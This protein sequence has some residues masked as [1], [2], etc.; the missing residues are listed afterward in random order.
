MRRRQNDGWQR[1]RPSSSKCNSEGGG[2][3]ENLKRPYESFKP[4][5][6]KSEPKWL[7]Q[8][9]LTAG[10]TEENK[11]KVRKYD[12][13]MADF[14]PEEKKKRVFNVRS[15][16]RGYKREDTKMLEDFLA[17]LYF[18]HHTSIIIRKRKIKKKTSVNTRYVRARLPAVQEKPNMR[19][20]RCTEHRHTKISQV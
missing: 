18:S 10:S 14:P 20:R 13:I 3:V 11:Q 4:R 1:S 17:C 6:G 19:G 5:R 2:G 15:H 8:V 9:H 16:S 12:I 7:K